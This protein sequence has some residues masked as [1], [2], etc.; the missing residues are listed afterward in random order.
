MF[1]MGVYA[2]TFLPPISAQNTTIL[3]QMNRNRVEQA[4]TPVATA[5][6]EVNNAQ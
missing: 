2:Q 6:P 5:A 1:W 3:N 4:A